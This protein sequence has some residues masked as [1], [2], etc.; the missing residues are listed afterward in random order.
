M[1][2]HEEG[3]MS[4]RRFCSSL[5]LLLALNAAAI[6]ETLPQMASLSGSMLFQSFSVRPSGTIDLGPS[7]VGVNTP[8]AFPVPIFVTNTG[9]ADLNIAPT[10]SNF[11][12]G[13]TAEST[14]NTPVTLA[15]GQTKEGDILFQPTAT[16]VRT[17]QFISTDNAPGSPHMV[18]LTGVGVAVPSNDFGIAADANITGVPSGKTTTFKIW[19]LA[20]PGLPNGPDGTLQCSGGPSGTSC[21]LAGSAF[22]IDDSSGFGS[23]RQSI[24]VT[25]TIPAK[26]A[27]LRGRPFAFWWGVPAV[28]ALALLRPHQRKASLALAIMSIALLS[29]LMLSCGGGSNSNSGALLFTASR[30]GATHTLSLPVQ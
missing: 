21:N 7:A 17:G 19:L 13:F 3:I 4:S 2:C 28:F 5:V 24:P 12:F 1:L 11:E 14:F 18:P 25:V 6:A 22:S 10:F 8:H 15:S 29:G 27:S 30:N 16:G 9:T 23:T 26:S 20:G